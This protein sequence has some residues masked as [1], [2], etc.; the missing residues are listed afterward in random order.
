[1]STRSIFHAGELAVQA[2]EGVVDQA[3]RLGGTIGSAL[4]DVA[5]EFLEM[6]EMLAIASVDPDGGRVWCSALTGP[7]G[8]A[9]A[10]DETTLMIHARPEP[11]DP[12]GETIRDEGPIGVLAIEPATRRRMKIKGRAR[13][14]D[15]AGYRVT[16]DRVYSLCPKYIQARETIDDGAA[17]PPGPRAASHAFG[18][19]L[20]DD[21]QRWIARA[22]TL[23]IATHSRDGG[24]D[25]SHRGGNPGFVRAIDGS[26]L[27]LPD[28]AGNNMFNTLGNLELDDRA[29]LLFFDFDDGRTLQ[30]S[31]RARASWSEARR[32]SFAGARRVVDFAVERVVEIRPA[33]PLRWRFLEPSRFNPR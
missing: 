16:T 3:R 11:G 33:R 19:R 7:P 13:V 17:A 18:D 6:Q 22:D 29:A 5:R 15:G 28:Y 25:A 32:A 10:P 31:G 1:M 14:E 26:R 9:H 2:R 21:Q 24:P 8:F 27:E 23:V 20:T 4:P 12:L 30:L